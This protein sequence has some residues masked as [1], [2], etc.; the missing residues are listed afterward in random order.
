MAYTPT[1]IQAPA[2]HSPYVNLQNAMRRRNYALGQMAER[3]WEAAPDTPTFRKILQSIW[4]QINNGQEIYVVGVIQADAG[5]LQRLLAGSVPSGIAE[6]RAMPLFAGNA[7]G[8]FNPAPGWISSSG[9]ASVLTPALML[10]L[11]CAT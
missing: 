6:L 3:R 4:Y 7:V 1:I 10:L 5:V 9:S 2:R 11:T 8:P